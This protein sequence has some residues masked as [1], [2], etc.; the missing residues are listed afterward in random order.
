MRAKGFAIFFIYNNMILA[1]NLLRYMQVAS[2]IVNQAIILQDR[3]SK[4]SVL[5]TFC[6]PLE[7]FFQLFQMNEMMGPQE[8]SYAVFFKR[9]EIIHDRATGQLVVGRLVDG[10]T[11]TGRL[12]GRPAGRTVSRMDGRSDG[13]RSDGWT[14][15]RINASFE[16]VQNNNLPPTVE[17]S[18][19]KTYTFFTLNNINM[20]RSSK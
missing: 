11:S 2:F 6:Q 9:K 19:T 4:I 14:A 3:I 10:R 16:Q 18:Y 17:E 12:V 7:T 8:A 1:L 20:F 13:S 5:L 15:V